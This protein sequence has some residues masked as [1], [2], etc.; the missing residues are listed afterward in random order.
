MDRQWWKEASVYQ[1]YPRSFMDTDKD[2]IGDLRGI[3]SKLD[4]LK[5]LG[6]EVI[7]LSPFFDSPNDDNGYDIRDYRSIHPD[8]GTMEDFEAMLSGIHSRGMKLLIDL[9][10]N[11]SSDE[12]PWFLE[13]KQSRDNPYRD[14]YIWKD[15]RGDAPPNHW[16]SVFSGPAWTFD[17]TT[18]QYYLHLF[19]KKQP[20]L[21]WDNPRLRQEV[22]GIMNFWLAKGVDGFRMDVINLISK[23]F[24]PEGKNGEADG[25]DYY[26]MGPH[27]HEYLQE[28]NRTVLQ[29]R[30][31]M[32]VGECPGTTPEDAIDLTAPER[33]ELNMIFVFEHM[34]IDSGPL[35]KW[36]F[37]PVDLVKL[38]K[39]L[40][41]F[42]RELHG[43]AWNSLFLNNHD[44]P[45]M[46]SRFGD[47]REQ[48]R[49]RSAKMLAH[50]T[51]FMEG[52]PYIYQ[53]EEL[54]MTNLHLEDLEGLRDIE[55]INAYRDLTKRGVFSPE[56]MLEAIRRKGRDNARSPMQWTDEANGGFTRGTPWIGVNPNYQAINAAD[57]A[58]DRDSVLA[59]YKTI[60]RLRREIPVIVYGDYQPLYEEDDRLFA[61]T[62]QLGNE[63]L[64][65]LNNFTAE[66]LTVDITA[67]LGEEGW[68]LLLS[69]YGDRLYAGETRLTLRAYEGIVLFKETL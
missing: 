54:G 66:E 26:F 23:E 27:L 6:I 36:D 28:M 63:G 7:W 42:Q 8:F 30:D 38:K 64:I 11:H 65:C 21:N 48:Y 9:V 2:G 10:V 62:R 31:I 51:H 17:E 57:Q 34:D 61:W 68:E 13:S 14:Y 29:G 5:D 37:T 49:V 15:G 22:Y 40:G 59:Y 46:V 56:H 20:D 50:I 52:T 33:E 1:I 24:N 53:G 18:G 47:D 60:L 12:H 41:K 67:A 43:R 3:T 69:N 44:Q 58:G 35:G 45:R 25:G 39:I 32:T 19:S 4:Y 16:E 55:S